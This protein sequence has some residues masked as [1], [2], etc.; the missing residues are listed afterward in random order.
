MDRK[1][2][3]KYL[4]ATTGIMTLG[5]F[6]RLGEQLQVLDTT[7][8][9]LFVG[10]GSPMNA[11]EDNQF[12][13]RWS[14]L[15]K[16]I[17]KPKAVLCISAHWLSS[18]TK[19]TAMKA[20]KT[21]HDFGGFPKALFEV[22]YPAPGNP[23]L[24]SDVSKLVKK[25]N[26]GLD[27]E[28]GLDHGTWSIVRKMYPDADIPVLQMSIDYSKPMQY[29]YELAKELAD[30]RNKG[31]LIIGSGNMIHNLGMVAWD[32]LNDDNYG[33]DWAI[34]LNETLKRNIMEKKHDNLINYSSMGKP[35]ALAIPSPDHY[36][37]ML[38]ALGLQ[39][40]K[41]SITFFNDKL[42]AGSLNMTSFIVSEDTVIVI[43][44]PKA[45]DDSLVNTDS[46]IS[47]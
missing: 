28:W 47:R 18:G 27:H 3:L 14:A 19:I 16:E 31:V 37:P 45:G 30:L 20:P 7:M 13:R 10:H 23:E 25:T 42:V 35:A 1:E 11:I 6:S 39:S 44:P 12:S 5:S 40:E 33:Y 36:I 26:V 32:K 2:F 29:H 22:Q 46:A 21:I 43:E 15:G 41:E 4:A 8:P 38:Y 24:A 9:V 34:E 17:V